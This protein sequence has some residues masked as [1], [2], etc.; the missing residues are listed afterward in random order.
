M[1]EE[2]G[3]D[4][5]R[6]SALIS[7][8]TAVL[9]G[10]GIP[11]IE[12][13][14]EIA[15]R[16][17][18]AEQIQRGLNNLAEVLLQEGEIAVV[19]P[20]FEEMRTEAERFGGR[21]II[22]WLNAQEATYRW[23]TGGW[24]TATR[25]LDVFLSEVEMGSPHYQEATARQA[26]AQIRYARGDAEGAFEDGE[27]GV[28]AARAARDPQA[29]VSMILYA[30]LLLAESRVDE[31]IALAQEAVA[32]GYLPYYVTVD[33]AWVV[34][35]GGAALHN[36]R[37]PETTEPW[38]TLAEAIMARDFSAVA[39]LLADLGLR[40]DEAFARLR[41]ASDLVAGGRRGEANGQLTRALAYY[42]SVGATRYIR[43]GEA[44]LAKS[45]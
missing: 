26:R 10:A 7:I 19:G 32:P 3:L 15:R 9:G 35:D 12:R 41:A 43:E 34:L 1:A 40:N 37:V 27:R 31:A 6:A 21:L 36:L 18:D 16:I 5:V 13:G 22:Q 39:E 11:D 44:L 23:Y 30:R 20:L 28:A 29:L 4:R 24:D 8:G 45:A 25:L 42:R 33:L 17:N 2:L 38:S 14:L